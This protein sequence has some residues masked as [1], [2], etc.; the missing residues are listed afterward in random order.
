MVNNLI[1]GIVMRQGKFFAFEGIDG[2]GLTTQA[3]LLKDWLEKQGYAVFMTK[4]PTDGPIGGQIR[5]A[6]GKRLNM[7]PTALALAFAAD[8]MDHLETE[9]IP[10]LDNGVIV[11]S[12]RYFLSSY[13]YQSL[14]NDLRWLMQINSKCL[15]PGL[16]ILLD[17]PALVCKKR[18]E[19][20]RWHIE[21]Y[22]EIE[23]LEV[24]R[25]KFLSVANELRKNGERIE[26]I[27]GNRPVTTVHK[28]VKKAVTHTLRGFA[29]VR[30]LSE[31]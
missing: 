11:I 8:R 14:S 15:R 23:K 3:G 2:A 25:K 28:D 29:R 20:M 5:L 30:P 13:A 22:E 26:I 1:E 6:L 16:T 17:T 31:F 18:M 9:I 4:E 12:D 21:L 19:R 10:K 24:V 27:D 7:R